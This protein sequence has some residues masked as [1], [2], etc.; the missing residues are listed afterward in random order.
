MSNKFKLSNSLKLFVAL[1]FI[2]PGKIALA[3]RADVERACLDYIEGF[4][5]GD[6]M[7]IHNSIAV[8]VLKHGFFTEKNK[9][10]Y[11]KDT[12]TYQQCIDYAVRVNKRGVSPKVE[13]YPK[14]VEIFDV[15]DKTASAKITAWWGTDY[16]LLAKLDGAWKITHV[17]WQSFP[18]KS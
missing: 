14:K 13:S 11:T 2:L 6:S 9:P 12:M 18:E 4:Y 7:K 8:D 15:L 10:G 16:V 17:L 3:Q 1:L 5:Y